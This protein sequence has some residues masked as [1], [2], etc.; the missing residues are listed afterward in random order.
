MSTEAFDQTVDPFPKPPS[1]FTGKFVYYKW[2]KSL[3]GQDVLSAPW[4]QPKE[5]ETEKLG[6]HLKEAPT[7]TPTPTLKESDTSTKINVTYYLLQGGLIKMRHIPWLS[8]AVSIA[9]ELWEKS[10]RCTPIHVIEEG[11][12]Y[13]LVTFNTLGV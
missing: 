8:V 13:E 5:E 6:N 1:A 11:K 3:V 10:S 12:Q 4:I 9:M 7:P 2:Y